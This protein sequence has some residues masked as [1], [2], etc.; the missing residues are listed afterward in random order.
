MA[1]ELRNMTSGNS[2]YI[3]LTGFY[4]QHNIIVYSSFSINNNKVMVVDAV[5]GELVSAFSLINRE[6]TGKN[7]HFGPL[8]VVTTS[9]CH[10]FQGWQTFF[11]KNGNREI[12]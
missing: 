6:N 4:R 7:L 3:A 10:G 8:L 12:T 9:Y 1:E 2:T 11:P 5:W